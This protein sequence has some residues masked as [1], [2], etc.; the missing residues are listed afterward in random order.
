MKNYDPFTAM[1]ERIQRCLH[2]GREMA[3]APLAYAENPNCEV[4][5]QDRIDANAIPNAPK[6]WVRR[7]EFMRLI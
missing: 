6:R 3:V 7:G 1:L 2:C 5:L 4:C